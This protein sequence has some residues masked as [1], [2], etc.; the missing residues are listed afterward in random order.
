MPVA[1]ILPLVNTK[2]ISIMQPVSLKISEPMYQQLLI[3]KEE[4][5][6]GNISD[7][8][9]F[10]LRFALENYAKEPTRK[11]QDKLQKQVLS[12]AIMSHCL[13]EQ[14][15]LT[16]AEDGPQLQ[17]RANTK[18]EKLINSLLQKSANS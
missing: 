16:L 7:V 11:H 1:K 13:I 5:S 10:L 12:Y 3:K 14:S 17:E 9:R 18:A 2:E 6:I 8:I 15:V 4:L